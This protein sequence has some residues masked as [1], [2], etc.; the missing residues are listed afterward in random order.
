[1]VTFFLSFKVPKDGGHADYAAFIEALPIVAPPEVFGLDDNATLTKDQNETT[2]MFAT[3]LLTQGGGGGGGGGGG[4][5]KDAAVDSVAADV[6][7][8][9]PKI[10]D[11]EEVFPPCV[12]LDPRYVVLIP[13][14]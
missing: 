10:F 2:A 11:M 3:I 6:L 8:K 13:R 7:S 14:W 1:M 9:L 12:F 5:G 4:S